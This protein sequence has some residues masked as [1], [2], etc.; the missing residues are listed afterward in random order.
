MGAQPVNNLALENLYVAICVLPNLRLHT[1]CSLLL[2]GESYKV[3][4]GLVVENLLDV[5]G[6]LRRSLMQLS[7]AVSLASL[8]LWGRDCLDAHQQKSLPQMRQG[9]RRDLAAPVIGVKV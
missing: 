7:L 2:C 6:P 5:F 1:Y 3:C 4:R 8:T 9:C